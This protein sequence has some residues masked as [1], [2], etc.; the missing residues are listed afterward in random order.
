[1]QPIE[2]IQ[3]LYTMYRY[4]DFVYRVVKFKRSPP[5]ITL[6]ENREE[7]AG[8]GRLSQS[9]S[10]SRS[11]VLQLAL[12]NKWDYFI[13]LTVNA[14]RHD[15]YDLDS[16]YAYLSQWIRDWR[17]KWGG[18][19]YVLVPERHEN[20][21]WHFHGFVSDIPESQLTDFV[22][23]IHPNKLVDRGYL[24]W[25]AL[26]K[27]VGFVSLSR[28]ENP[29]GAAFYMAKYVTKEHA[30]DDYYT[31]LYYC[32]R[33]LNRAIPAYDFYG[34][35]SELESVL[36]HDCDFCRTGWMFFDSWSGALDVGQSREDRVDGWFNNEQE[37]LALV[38]A[39]EIEAAE[40]I[41]ITGWLNE[42]SCSGFDCWSDHYCSSVYA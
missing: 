32:S 11:T 28:V 31:H 5:G 39:F 34:Y 24:N 10:R 18:L 6:H 13:T 23:G 37:R 30:N 38:D 7:V 4:T 16:T 8:D 33:G 26:S 17:K 9:Y 2:K 36:V 42:I 1:M 12:C 40:Q 41:S 29:T 21:A 14:D 3:P 20:G 19:K 27:A 22:R 15:R 35:E 25:P